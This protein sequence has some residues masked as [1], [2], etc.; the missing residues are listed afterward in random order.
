LFSQVTNFGSAWLH[1]G[2]AGGW[3]V[4]LSSLWLHVGNGGFVC[5][6][7]WVKE[8]MHKSV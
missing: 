6:D 1:L 7:A 3:L 8:Q 5:M 4:V 2:C